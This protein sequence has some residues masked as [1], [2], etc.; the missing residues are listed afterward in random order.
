M[1]GEYIDLHCDLGVGDGRAR[2][3]TNDLTYGYID[4][5]KGTS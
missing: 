4:E 1:A 5:N 2:I 3:L